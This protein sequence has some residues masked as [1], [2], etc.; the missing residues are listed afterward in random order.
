MDEQRGAAQLPGDDGNVPTA[1]AR[2]VCHTPEPRDTEIQMAIIMPGMAIIT[3]MNRI[4][5]LSVS[6]PKKPH[7]APTIM[8]NTMPMATEITAT[9]K[10]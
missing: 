4:R 7:R 2:A 6:L 10:E 8:P 9:I 5:I 1:M 3:S